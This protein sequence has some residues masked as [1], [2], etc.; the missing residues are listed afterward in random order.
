M[1]D[2]ISLLA[3]IITLRKHCS[4][5]PTG[6]LPLSSVR[7]ATVFVDSTDPDSDPTRYAV[8]HFFSS[9]GISVNII[10]PQKWDVNWHGWLKKP[11]T[12]DP[13]MFISLAY[14]DNFASEHAAR[15]STARFKVGRKQLKGNVF[16]MVLINPEDQ[17][18]LQHNAFE[19]IIELLMKVE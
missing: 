14:Y 1:T 18:T 16:D 8:Q 11:D 17:L 15:C 2:P 7:R 10:C 5:V 12:T 3:R 6:I 4:T 19:A 9:K 13:D